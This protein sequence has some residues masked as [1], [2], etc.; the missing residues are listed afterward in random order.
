MRAAR[1]QQT[2]TSAAAPGLPQ[3]PAPTPAHSEEIRAAAAEP[4]SPA[5]PRRGRK[6]LISGRFSAHVLRP[7][8]AIGCSA[9]RVPGRWKGREM[10]W[11][12][13]APE[14]GRASACV[15]LCLGRVLVGRTSGERLG[16][17]SGTAGARRLERDELGAAPLRFLPLVGLAAGPV[18]A[19]DLPP[20]KG[21]EVSLC[22]RGCGTCS[23]GLPVLA[24]VGG[25]Q[26]LGISTSVVFF[27]SFSAS[28][29]PSC[30]LLCSCVPLLSFC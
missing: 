18:P 11:R 6:E 22:F 2:R 24:G 8:H 14:G 15:G 17:G 30:L 23:R 27:T 3:C 5:L 13:A 21:Q 20:R 10:R 28:K 26:A 9:R 12:R 4:I 25:S 1:R 16:G 29:S 19:P 7:G